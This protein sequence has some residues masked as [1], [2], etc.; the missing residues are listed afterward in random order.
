LKVNG[1]M[2]AEF[3]ESMARAG[4]LTRWTVFL[5]GGGSGS[6]VD[7]IPG[8][9]LSM[10]KRT[11]ERKFDDRYAIGRLLDPRDEAVD[12]DEAQWKAA[13]AVTRAAR[14]ADPGRLLDTREPEIPN[15]PSIRKIRGFGAEGIPPRPERGLLI[16]YAL[17]PDKAEIG[18]PEGTSPVIAFGVSFPGSDSG[19]KVEYKVNNV[20]WEQ[21]YGP[22]D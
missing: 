14:K 2:L 4:E 11:G 19:L 15:G 21:E 6:Q 9:R 8:L 13:L 22:A 16:L 5:A 1:A 12:L 18:F 17:D 20:L 7:L 10:S 3:V